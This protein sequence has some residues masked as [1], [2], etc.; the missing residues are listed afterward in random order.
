MKAFVDFFARYRPELRE[1]LIPADEADIESL[2]WLSGGLPGAY[3]RFL[4][5]MGGSVGGLEVAEAMVDIEGVIAAYLHF[6]WLKRERYLMIGGD[7]GLAAL[8][9]FLDR[10]RRHGS[11]DCMLVRMPLN[12]AFD[13]DAHFPVHAGVEEWLFYETFK[14]VRLPLLAHR[15]EFK[16]DRVPPTTH[17]KRA[18]VVHAFAEEHGFSRIPPAERCALYDRSDAGLLLYQHPIE[19]TISFTLGCDDPHELARLAKEL[20]TRTG[21]RGRP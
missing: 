17:A 8:Y 10:S 16:E 9:Y 7:S 1:D 4:R 13:A 18:Q 15:I 14:S 5:T 19:P 12:K 3:E 11:D 2:D 6:P 21:L 20:E